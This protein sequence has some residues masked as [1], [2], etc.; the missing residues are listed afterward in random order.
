MLPF[1]SSFHINDFVFTPLIEVDDE[2]DNDLDSI[3]CIVSNESRNFSLYMVFH[4]INTS[5]HTGSA[6]NIDFMYF[7]WQYL[8]RFSFKKHALVIHPSDDLFPTRPRL[9]APQHYRALSDG[10]RDRH[11]CDHCV[12]IYEDALLPFS[13]CDR[14]VDDNCACPI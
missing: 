9:L 13:S 4:G 8:D 11:D 12:R 6:S 3:T 5:T 2:E 7:I 1:N 10:W 14:L